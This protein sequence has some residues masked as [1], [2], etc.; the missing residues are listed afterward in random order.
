MSFLSWVIVG[1]LAGW[2]AS[3][4]MGKNHKIGLIG[5]IILGVIGAFVGGFILQAIGV[6]GDVTGINISSILVATLGAVVIL[7]IANKIG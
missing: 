5:N 1:A 6:G 3:I 2:I 4:I 7:F